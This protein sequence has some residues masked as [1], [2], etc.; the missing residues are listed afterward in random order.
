[1][2]TTFS[3]LLFHQ[4]KGSAFASMG[5]LPRKIRHAKGLHFLKMMGSGKGKAFSLMPDFSRYCLL[6]TW[7][8]ESSADTFFADNKDWLAYRNSAAASLHFHLHAL[9]AKGTWNKQQPFTHENEKPVGSEPLA[10]LTRA[11]LDWKR[12]PSFW[13]HA[14]KS[15][16]DLP[17]ADGLFYSIGIGEIPYLEQ[18]TFSLWQNAEKMK[19]FVSAPAHLQAIRM[20]HQEKWYREELFARFRIGAIQCSHPSLF[21]ELQPLE[22]WMHK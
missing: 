9:S 10:V 1:M 3:I 22:A 2:L 19:A 11:S 14:R 18:A 5:L 7:N 6:G 21:P 8:D 17:A 20:R 16:H 15:T 13:H 12:L 4:N